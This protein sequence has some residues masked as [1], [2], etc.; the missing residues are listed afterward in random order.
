M[1]YDGQHQTPRPADAGDFME[2]PEPACHEHAAFA[3]HSPIW[4]QIRIGGLRWGL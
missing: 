2:S 3:L 4:S 1:Q